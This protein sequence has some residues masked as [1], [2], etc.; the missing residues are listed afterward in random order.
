M[1][2]NFG[3][4]ALLLSFALLLSACGGGGVG[5]QPGGCSSTPDPDA[6][7]TPGS[8]MVKVNAQQSFTASFSGTLIWSVNGIVGGNATV[9]T[10]VST[11]TPNGPNSALYTAPAS[12]PSPNTVTVNASHCATSAN[13]TVTIVP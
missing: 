3:R 5:T 9:G 13:A 8:V 11:A 4:L 2:G 7:I 10:I 12:V 6:I 1:W